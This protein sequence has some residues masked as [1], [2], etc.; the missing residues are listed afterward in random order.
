MALRKKYGE[1][2]MHD[3]PRWTRDFFPG[4]YHLDLWSDVFGDPADAAQYTETT[5]ERTDMPFTMRR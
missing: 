3:L 4:V 5:V 2:T 1:I